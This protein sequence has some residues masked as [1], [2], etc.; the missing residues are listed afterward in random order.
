[1]KA[2]KKKTAKVTQKKAVK[3]KKVVQKAIKKSWSNFNDWWDKVAQKKAEKIER[4]WIKENEP[5]DPEEEGGDHWC[6]NEMMHSGDALEMVYEKAQEVW[7][8]AIK[9]KRWEMSQCDSLYCE[10]DDII[11][12]AYEAGRL[13]KK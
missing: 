8:T 9:G 11:V 6:V 7:E 10:L 5:N 3:K 1:M 12:E 4:N 2:A 13:S